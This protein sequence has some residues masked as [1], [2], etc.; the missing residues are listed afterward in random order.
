MSAHDLPPTDLLARRPHAWGLRLQ[1]VRHLVQLGFA[2]FIAG[3][4]IG[5]ELLPEGAVPSAEA[6]CPFGGMETLYRWAT[7]GKFIEHSH[8]SNFVL[9]IAILLTAVVGRGFFCGWVC[10]FDPVDHR[11]DQSP[12]TATPPVPSY[13]VAGRPRSIRLDGRA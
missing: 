7:S 5:H 3:L 11:T 13:V 4:A 6:Y 1:Q 9:F 8:A 12:A 2:L 10:P